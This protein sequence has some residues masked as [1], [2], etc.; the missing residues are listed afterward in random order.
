MK[1]PPIKKHF[2]LIELLVVIAIIAI[3]AAMLLPA[4]SKAREKARAISCVNNLKHLGTST[5][6]YCDDND[7]YTFKIGKN[8]ISGHGSNEYMWP[9][10][11]SELDYMKKGNTFYCPSAQPGSY[12]A[13]VA[14]GKTQN[15]S[16]ANYWTYITYGMRQNQAHPNSGSSI[17]TDS[18]PYGYRLGGAEISTRMIAYVPAFPPS[19]FYL[20]GDTINTAT[21]VSCN[22]IYAS[23]S[24]SCTRGI[25]LRHGG[26]ANLWFCDGHVDSLLRGE[27]TDENRTAKTQNAA[28]ID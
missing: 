7:G 16:D 10:V 15:A 28:V 22:V 27:I 24:S 12:S 2:T 26:R 18:N 20:Y 6:L 8:I 11:L 5:L 14:Y 17:D 4:L 25:K 13:A 19:I 3:L 1:I 21:N 23:G 9:S